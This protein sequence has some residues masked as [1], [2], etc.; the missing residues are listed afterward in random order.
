MHSLYLCVCS[1]VL[2]KIIGFIHQNIKVFPL[3]DTINFTDIQKA[4]I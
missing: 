4:K 2:K 1:I 3:Y